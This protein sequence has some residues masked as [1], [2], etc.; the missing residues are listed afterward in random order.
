MAVTLWGEV[1]WFSPYVFSVF[2]A[3]KEKGVP[4]ETKLIDVYSAE[5]HR[6][7]YQAHT[8]TARVPSLEHDGFWLAESSAIIEYVDETF[9]GPPLLPRDAKER[10]RARQVMAWLRSDLLPL[11]DEY[12]TD[13][14]FYERATA[15]LRA[16]GKAA[17]KLVDRMAGLDAE[18]APGATELFST[19]SSAD[20]DLTFALH[21]LILNGYELPSKVRAYA[22]RQWQ[23]PSLRAFV[24][25]PRPKQGPKPT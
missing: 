17:E 1:Y 9:E 4:F 7:D 18:L 22:D 19:W 24:E 2:A 12:A 16:R 14:M 8:V 6:P 10:A 25:H 11:R 23:R 21:R 13:T 3:L 15:A 5:Q 20:A